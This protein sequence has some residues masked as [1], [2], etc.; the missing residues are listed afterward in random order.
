M[1]K[2]SSYKL[3]DLPKQKDPLEELFNTGADEIET[4]TMKANLGEQYIFIKQ[5]KTVL[6]K[7]GIQARVPYEMIIE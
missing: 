4:R 3:I 6:L 5:L 2:L 7:K 1:A